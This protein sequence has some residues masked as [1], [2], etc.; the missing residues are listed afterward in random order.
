MWL[1]IATFVEM[2]GKLKRLYKIVNQE[3]VVGSEVAYVLMHWLVDML[4]P[5]FYIP[6]LPRR[7]GW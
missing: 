7:V 3:D 2:S 5:C 6:C 4:F 1:S